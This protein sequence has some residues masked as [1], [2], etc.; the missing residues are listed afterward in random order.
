MKKN[1]QR[2]RTNFLAKYG[3]ISLYDI[4][5]EKIYSIYEKEINFVKGYRYDLIGNLDRKK[6]GV[7]KV[8]SE[9]L[10]PVKR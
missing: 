2:S 3:W 9:H 4:D 6:W 7:E 8:F 5:M 10:E 1:D